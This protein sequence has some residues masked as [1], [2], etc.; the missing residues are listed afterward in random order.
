MA[1]KVLIIDDNFDDLVTLKKILEKEGFQVT[2]ATNGAQALDLMEATRFDLILIDIRMPT[3]SGYDLL[4]LIRNKMNHSIPLIFVSII[5]KREVV[6]TD[7]DGFIQKPFSP[8]TV[9]D[10][11]KKALKAKR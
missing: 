7:A 6:L 10:E 2:N 9:V 1:K 5:P 3:V 4:M 8:K 11:V